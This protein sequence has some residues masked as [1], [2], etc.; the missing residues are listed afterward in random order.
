[1]LRL[2]KAFRDTHDSVTY[3]NIDLKSLFEEIISEAQ[4]IANNL[5]S[6][7]DLDMLRGYSFSFDTLYVQTEFFIPKLLKKLPKK[8]RNLEGPEFIGRDAVYK[9]P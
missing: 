3:G 6:Y 4:V 2:R 1:M 7:F 9:V 5:I 8:L